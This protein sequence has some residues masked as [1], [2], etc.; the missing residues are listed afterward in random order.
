[1]RYVTLALALMACDTPG[2]P[3]APHL[4]DNYLEGVTLCQEAKAALCRVYSS[5]CGGSNVVDD[6]PSIAFF[7]NLTDCQGVDADVN[8][9][10]CIE[11][12][13]DVPCPPTEAQ[14]TAAFDLCVRVAYPHGSGPAAPKSE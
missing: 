9:R 7:Y 4:F 11:A 10:P 13:D 3:G 12:L 2:T 1:M 5:E 14:Q 8:W 6:C